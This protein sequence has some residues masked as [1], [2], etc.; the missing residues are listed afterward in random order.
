MTIPQE[1]AD[2]QQLVIESFKAFR[3]EL[4]TSF[5]N[6]AFS[7]K[8]DHTQVTE[9]DVRIEKSLQKT[10]QARF[11]ELGFRGEETGH[12]GDDTTYW[13]VDPIDGTSSF[14]RGLPFCTNMA[15]LIHEGQT[16]LSVI[17]DFVSDRL[18]TAQKGGGAFCDGQR[19]SV[20]TERDAGNYFV[21]SFTRSNFA[22]VDE[23]MKELGVRTF[24]PVGAAGHVYIQ[25]ASGAIDGIA[26]LS[27]HGRA[28]DISPGL[29][30]CEE[31]G[32]T[33]F[34]YDDTQRG[35]ERNKFIVAAPKLVESIEHSGLFA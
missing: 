23:A 25:L 19:L 21:Y 30:L 22:L 12:H 32:A 6:V 15:A 33:V 13:L 14:I 35:I 17:Y 9:L 7:R 8:A 20:N 18:Y 27:G 1:W 4:L 3:T 31:A 10:L 28:H 34:L 29:L 2:S 24:L 5:G 26:T 11:P 16:V